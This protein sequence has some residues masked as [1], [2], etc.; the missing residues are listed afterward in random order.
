MLWNAPCVYEAIAP[1]CRQKDPRGAACVA[2]LADLGCL[3]FNDGDQQTKKSST[4]QH[5]RS[6]P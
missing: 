4:P 1:R 6:S 3:S 5:E 2:E